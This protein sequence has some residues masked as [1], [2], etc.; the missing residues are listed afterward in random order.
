MAKKLTLSDEFQHYDTL[1]WQIPTWGM[2]IAMGSIVGALQIGGV[3]PGA[4]PAGLSVG[5]LQACVL[6]CAFLLLLS[7]SITLY[8]Y[9]AFQ[10]ASVP[11]PLPCPP[12]GRQPSANKFLQGAMCITTGII[13]GLA[14]VATGVNPAMISIILGI[15][16]GLA[17][18]WLAEVKNNEIVLEINRKFDLKIDGDGPVLGTLEETLSGEQSPVN[19]SKINNSDKVRV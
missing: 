8:R 6:G 17:G 14:F 11:S 18:W 12:F 19:T 13:G 9:R 7:S 1:I 10:A 4:I 3:A 5:L 15:I 2:T 16:I